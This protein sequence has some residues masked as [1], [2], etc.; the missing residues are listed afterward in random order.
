MPRLAKPKMP[1]CAALRMLLTGRVRP[2]TARGRSGPGLSIGR[3][4]F[5]PWR[6]V[7]GAGLAVETLGFSIRG[8]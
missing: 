8:A 6:G 2:Y 3:S 5:C 4:E 7:Y 1:G